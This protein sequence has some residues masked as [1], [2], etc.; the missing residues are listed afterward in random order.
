MSTSPIPETGFSETLSHLLE[1]STSDHMSPILSESSGSDA[2][3][4]SAASDHA[5]SE[6]TAPTTPDK[7]QAD[8]PHIPIAPGRPWL[9]RSESQSTIGKTEFPKKSSTRADSVSFG[10]LI[11]EDPTRPSSPERSVSRNKSAPPSAYPTRTPIRTKRR[12]VTSNL[13][14]PT[15]PTGSPE[16]M[17]PH[18]PPQPPDY[19]SLLSTPHSV[20]FS[21]QLE[22]DLLSSLSLLGFDTSQIVH[23]VLTDACDATG[24]IWWMLKKKAEK[25]EAAEARR[26]AEERRKTLEALGDTS[27]KRSGTLS[28]H[29]RSSPDI[30]EARANPPDVSDILP[31]QKPK[32]SQETTLGLN[33]SIS[34]LV[35]TTGTPD[36][37]FVPPTPIIPSHDEPR[38]PP[39]ALTPSGSGS[40]QANLGLD[41]SGLMPTSSPASPRGKN[42]KPRSGSVSMLQRAAGALVRKKSEEKVVPKDDNP[43]SI[44]SSATEPSP[45]V[46]AASSPSLH[47]V[48]SSGGNKLTKSPP[49]YKGKD[50]E[51]SM[52]DV[53][54]IS[55]VLT[56]G[57][58][59]S[60]VHAPNAPPPSPS[61]LGSR[62]SF[63]LKQP[64][65]YLFLHGSH[66]GDA[67]PG[68]PE[69]PHMQNPT[70]SKGRASIL[71]AFRTWFNEDKRKGKLKPKPSNIP[72]AGNSPVYTQ[73]SALTTPLSGRSSS[74]HYRAA[75]SGTWR[76]KKG[77]ARRHTKR[78]SVS[79]RRS[80]SVNSRRSS[81]NS[82]QQG[83]PLGFGDPHFPVSESMP[84]ISRQRSDASRKSYGSR[85]PNSERGEFSS[86]PS[87]IRSFNVTPMARP[88]RRSGSPSVSSV[89]SGNMVRRTSS[90]MLHYHR[91]AGSA[92]ST[93]VVRQVKTVHPRPSHLR[94]NSSASSTHSTSR[95]GSYHD[96]SPEAEGSGSQYFDNRRSP[97]SQSLRHS[98]EE[99]RAP[100]STTVLVAHKQSSVFSA[101]NSSRLQLNTGRLSW[102]K[103]WGAEPP[104]WSSRATYAPREIDTLSESSHS[105]RDVFTGR[106]SLDPNDDSDWVDEDDDGPALASGFGQAIPSH[107]SHVATPLMGLP[108]SPS[109]KI[110]MELPMT[111]NRPRSGPAK[112]AASRTNATSDARSGNVRTSPTPP[113]LSN[114]DQSSSSSPDEPHLASHGSRARRQLPS[115]R[116]GPTLRAL[117]IQEEDE[118]EE[119]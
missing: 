23:S 94:T 96:G 70:G 2:T 108:P 90:P 49:S 28:P 68:T 44:R 59:W 64:S 113:I 48:T 114:S 56:P 14:N 58:P 13:S 91:R 85:T 10:P 99:R 105:V 31:S 7:E 17:T 73:G 20:V 33:T 89:G 63:K 95:P 110:K 61:A 93:R 53:P 107:A 52:E 65:S 79:S 102:K 55:S 26:V 103:S 42:G 84:N 87:S 36:I 80:S 50:K 75:Q 25:R 47:H 9:Q 19:A 82:V 6:F 1:A 62:P 12:S 16:S 24:A 27:K 119:D 3:Y 60:S 35:F 66:S 29:R 43:D 112:R 100:Y 57:S 32:R 111:T 104:G 76:A 45:A 109:L 67:S 106:Q 92:S 21:T 88:K 37:G 98:S 30:L 40:M 46:S 78:P 8:V 4:H 15:S 18:H 71:T 22:Q 11:E 74:G 41:I 97:S 116:N 117:A 118:E 38:T 5:S 51:T 83:R 39:R 34:P 81:I 54:R 77:S 101:S 86:R 72:Q 69:D 115:G